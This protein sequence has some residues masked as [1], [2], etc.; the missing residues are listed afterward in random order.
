M[1]DQPRRPRGDPGRRVRRHLPALREG[2]EALGPRE[3]SGR[4]LR[5][6]RGPRR[7]SARAPPAWSGSRRPTNPLLTIADIEA[8]ASIAHDAGAL[9]VVDNTFASPYLQQPLSLGADIVVHSTTKYVGGHSDVVGGAVVVRDLD[10]AEAITFHQNAMG[11]VP[12]PVR[13]LPDPPRHQDARGPDGPA[14]RQ[15]RAGGRVPDRRTRRSRRR[16]TPGSAR[17]PRPRRGR[18]A[19]EAVRRHGQLPARRRR[20]GRASTPV[21]ARRCSRSGSRS[22]ASRA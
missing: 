22:A 7:R 16:S 14:L 21:P 5:P 1:P 3:H 4:D 18:P 2:R 9:L 12:G 6:R 13:L 15:R 20:A 17:A 10:L 19:D 11:A 8:L